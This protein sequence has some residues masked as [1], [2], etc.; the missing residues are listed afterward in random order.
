MA[1]EPL[2]LSPEMPASI[3][4]EDI[5]ELADKLSEHLSPYKDELYVLGARVCSFGFEPEAV[6]ELQIVSNELKDH[7]E[8]DDL[9]RKIGDKLIE[10]M[11]N[12]GIYKEETLAPTLGIGKDLDQKSNN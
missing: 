12:A 4:A 2:P 9:S 5:N 1:A 6:E 7:P 11:K 8:H 3:M 10:L